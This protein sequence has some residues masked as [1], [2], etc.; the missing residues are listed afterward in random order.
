MIMA[1]IPLEE[2]TS[3]KMS[4]LFRQTDREASV[5]EMPHM[6]TE[7]WI[8]DVKAAFLNRGGTKPQWAF[9]DCQGALEAIFLKGAH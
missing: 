7:K 6:S 1:C 8:Y 5:L 3:F 2:G 9:G 4:R